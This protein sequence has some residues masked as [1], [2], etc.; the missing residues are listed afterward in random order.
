MKPFIVMDIVKESQK[1]TDI[2]HLEIGEP[3]LLPSPNVKEAALKVVK[4]EKVFYAET[5]GCLL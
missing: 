1:L 4:E 3:D 5:K 2:I